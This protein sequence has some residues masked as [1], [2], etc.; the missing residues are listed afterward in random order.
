MYMFIKLIFVLM[1]KLSLI[2]FLCMALSLIVFLCMALSYYRTYKNDHGRH[3]EDG[4]A[5]EVPNGYNA[6]QPHRD[7]KSNIL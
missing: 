1:F 4:L 3:L 6:N 5:R 2:L 7:R